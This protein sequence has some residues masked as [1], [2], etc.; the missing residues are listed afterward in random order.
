MAAGECI[1]PYRIFETLGRGGMG[2][3]YRARHVTTEQA[4]ALKTVHSTGSGTLDSLRREI[5]ALSRIRHPGVVRIVDHGAHFGLPWY[6]MDLL[7]GESLRRFGQRIWSPYRQSVVTMLEEGALSSTQQ[8]LTR[9]VSLGQLATEGLDAGSALA[10]PD[11][12][13]P[14]AGG[15]LPAVLAI[16]APLCATLAFLHGEGFINCDLKPENV[17]LVSGE[18]IVIDFGLTAYHPGSSG[19]EAL[20]AHRAMAGTLHYMSPEQIRGDFVDARAD[21]YALGCIL[22]EL[23]VGQPPFSGDPSG[24]VACHLGRM[25]TPPSQLVSGVPEQLERAVLRLMAKELPERYGYADEL[26][27][28]MGAISGSGSCLAKYPPRSYLYR[29]RL[30]G[31]EPLTRKMM[32]IRERA[33]LGSGAFVLIGGESGVGKTRFAME[34]TRLVSSSEVH[35]VTSETSPPSAVAPAPL[36]ALRSFLLA[37]AD[38]CQEGGPELTE[39]LL[40]DGQ[41]EL[42]RYEPLLE[43][44]PSRQSSPSLVALSV[45]A[46]RRRLFQCLADTLGAFAREKPLVWV[47]DDLGF[48]DELS[49]SFLASLKAAFLESHPLLIVATYRS[50]EP[51]EAIAA[52]GR[53]P[54]VGH[55][56][57]PRLDRGGVRSM[58]RDM[59][60]MNEPAND[61]TE[62]VARQTEGNPFFVTEYLREAVA[63]HVLRR[64]RTGWCLPQPDEQQRDFTALPIPSTLRELIERRLSKLTPAGLQV[65]AA[66]AVL[67]RESETEVLQAVAGLQEDAFTLALDELLRRQLLEQLRPGAVRFAHDK[68]REVCY[69]TTSADVAR[70]LHARA[71]DALEAWWQ[72]RPNSNRGCAAIGHHFAAAQR[73]EQAARAL[74]TAADHARLTHANGEALRLYQ[75]AVEQAREAQLQAAQQPGAWAERLLALHEARADVLSLTAQREAARS[76]YEQAL[77]RTDAQQRAQR[78]RLYRKLGKTWENQHRYEEALRAYDEAQTALGSEVPPQSALRDEWLQVRA[79]KLSVYYWLDRVPEM[80]ALIQLLDPL[81][82]AEASPLQRAEYYHAR[83]SRNLRR[84]RYVIR[85]QTLQFS[86]MYLN[87]A[88][89]MGDYGQKLAARFFLGLVLVLQGQARPGAQELGAALQ[90][91]ER[92]GDPTQQARCLTY[93]ALAARM[94]SHVKDAAS[95]TRRAVVVSEKAGMVDYVAAAHA[96]QAWLALRQADLQLALEQ[97]QR[98]LAIWRGEL[99]LV[100]PLHWMALLPGIE[101]AIGLEQLELAVSFA[102]DLLQ[103]RQQPLPGAAAD[104][105][106]R[107]VKCW[108][109]K[110]ASASLANLQHA[111]RCLEGTGYR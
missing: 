17:L 46:A 50:E 36:Q 54:H 72:R 91:A 107:A 48:A 7:E 23:L 41:A 33:L 53:Q 82:Q 93:L 100:F 8:L 97:A 28:L 98:A 6:A 15:Q 40:G 60:A 99:A 68:L 110:D 37:V 76:E 64:E 65:C 70:S 88:E 29:P 75:M 30:V 55:I 80:D 58:I 21:L 2:V 81:M 101:A 66:T 1:G 108:A 18:P 9:T 51:S 61:F 87:A 44:V 56:V 106:N 83:A 69:A 103:P 92:S 16:M 25:P 57:L 4:V 12:R 105:L 90:L 86:R 14:V 26:A 67:G 24:L 42:A 5:S 89:E 27:E 109:G 79:D 38:C 73:P 77:G 84:D 3:V 111:L 34:L 47:I 59:L 94:H 52:I 62:F 45:D 39:R 74:H 32:Q 35:V 20:E 63:A 31:R 104:A 96:N 11:E 43:Q 49:L 22:Y 95:F 19:R 10:V 102:D 78:S 71:G 85:E 13:R